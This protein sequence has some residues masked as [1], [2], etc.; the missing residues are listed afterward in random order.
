MPLALVGLATAGISAGASIY[1]ANKA[2]NASKDALSAQLAQQGKVWDAVSP[3]MSSGKNALL[4][5]SDPSKVLGNFQAS[6]DFQYRLGQSLDAVG[7]DKAVNGLLRSGSAL[8]AIT[9]KAGDMASGEFGNWWQHQ[10]GLA[11]M[12][13]QGAQVGAGVANA[14]SA[15]I[16]QNATVQGNAAIAN[17]NTI[18]QLGGS[19]TDIL[20]RYLPQS[21]AISGGG[22]SFGGG[23]AAAAAG[24]MG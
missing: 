2:A 18:G 6:P 12:G 1:G 23:L 13:L 11:G 4:Q 14:N 5:I 9:Q 16:G 7:T 17:G 10:S 15:A 3:Y 22:S 20:G 19:I 8:S 24:G 21:G